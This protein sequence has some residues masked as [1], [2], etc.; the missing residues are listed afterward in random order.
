MSVLMTPS[1]A[2]L[3]TRAP[4]WRGC[5]E[6]GCLLR[7]T[8]WN[9]RWPFLSK[10]WLS[11]QALLLD[12]GDSMR[13]WKAQMSRPRVLVWGLMTGFPW[14][15]TLGKVQEVIVYPACVVSRFK[16]FPKSF[17]HAINLHLASDCCVQWNNFRFAV[18]INWAWMKWTHHV[19]SSRVTQH[20]WSSWAIS[21]GRR[22]SSYW[23][24]AS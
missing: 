22:L 11:L 17:H 7:L 6:T 18:F 4:S 23:L 13:G 3:T 9:A 5:C 14:P 16:C 19:R 8:V 2:R 10:L 20:R 1:S 12:L 21:L 24:A 15:L